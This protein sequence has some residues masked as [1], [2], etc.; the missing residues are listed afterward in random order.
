VR[1]WTPAHLN[2]RPLD[3]TLGQIRYRTREFFNRL[4]GV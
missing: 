2:D 1:R 3:V 4:F